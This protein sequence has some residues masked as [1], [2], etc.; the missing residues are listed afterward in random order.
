MIGKQLSTENFERNA[1][2]KMKINDFTFRIRR[3][4]NVRRCL[5]VTLLYYRNPDSVLKSLRIKK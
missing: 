2:L 5:N 1:W 3:L 4:K